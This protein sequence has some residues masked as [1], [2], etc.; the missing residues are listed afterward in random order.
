[1]ARLLNTGRADYIRSQIGGLCPKQ[2]MILGSGL[3]YMGDI[4]E[5][6]IAVPYQNIPHFKVSTAPGHK[7]QL[8]FGTLEGQKV[9]ICRPYAPLRGLPY[10]GGKTTRCGC[11]IRWAAIP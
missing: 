1:M 6:P 3:G 11:S 9:V 4:V 8:V 7:G 2:A 10:E 5:N